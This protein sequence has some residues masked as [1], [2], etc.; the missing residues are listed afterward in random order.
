LRRAAS[1]AW[2]LLCACAGCWSKWL[3]TGSLLPNTDVLLMS[4]AGLMRVS[5]RGA[6][7]SWPLSRSSD[8]PATA[9]LPPAESP[10]AATQHHNRQQNNSSSRKMSKLL[11]KW[12]VY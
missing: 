2:L 4:T 7:L 12:L 5:P 6:L 1:S 9:R 10:P 11:L 3:L 8:S